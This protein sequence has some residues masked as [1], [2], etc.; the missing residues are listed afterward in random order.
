MLFRQ[1]PILFQITY[2]ILLLCMCSIPITSA[3][4][5]PAGIALWSISLVHFFKIEKG[6]C[7]KNR[8]NNIFFS[9]YLLFFLLNF[10]ALFYSHN[11]TIAFSRME[12]YLW[13]FI[14]PPLFLVLD[15][16]K[17]TR[18][19]IENLLFTFLISM[20]FIILLNYAVSYKFFLE[21]HSSYHFFYASLSHFMHPSYQ[22]LYACIALLFSFYF[23]TKRRCMVLFILF[24]LVL[25]LY[26][27]MLQS[28]SGIFA[29]ILF[30]VFAGLYVMNRKKIRYIFSVVFVVVF[31]AIPVFLVKNIHTKI[32][33]VDN[34]IESL[35]KARE[36]ENYTDTRVLIWKN[37][38]EVAVENLPFG[39][40]IGDVHDALN[41]TYEANGFP[42]L[43]ERNYNA[44]NQYLETLI[45]SGIL[46]LLSLLSLFIFPFIYGVKNRDILLSVFVLIVLF[47]LLFESMLE[48]KAGGDFIALFL[49]LLF[50]MSKLEIDVER[51]YY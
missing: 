49:A 44:H 36:N 10:I 7:L 21:T 19:R 39:T 29:A 20:A 25:L 43:H 16:Q 31:L 40:G 47:F 5:L 9:L 38:W 15:S 4:L 26:V 18:K 37:A 41:R 8:E 3:L 17:M 51:K 1:E 34:F 35:K 23:I 12:Y 27:F 11:K 22:A 28:K 45:G 46:G 30:L 13:F 24:S 48:R 42:A 14:A 32:N 33:R 2:I 50:Y 6:T